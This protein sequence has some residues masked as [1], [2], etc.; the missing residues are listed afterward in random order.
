MTAN[1]GLDHIAQN[2][3][4]LDYVCFIDSDLIYPPDLFVRLIPHDKEV[5]AP[6]IMAADA[7]YDIWGFR[8]LDGEGFSP[9]TRD[10]LDKENVFEVSSVGGTVLIKAQA[11]YDGVRFGEGAIVSLCANLRKYGYRVWC[12]PRTVV[13]HPVAGGPLTYEGNLLHWPLTY[14]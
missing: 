9:F 2:I 6:L 14:S 10:L 4:D 11:I 8:K 12:D 1:A 3:P 5:V 13:Y 7:F